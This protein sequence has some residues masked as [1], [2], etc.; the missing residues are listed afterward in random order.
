MN[1]HLNH[2]PMTQEAPGG[3]ITT[4][5]SGAVAGFAA[6]APMTVAME[7]MHRR[8]PWWERYPLPPS[9]IV[10][11]LA[12]ATGLRKHMDRQEHL[13]VT[14]VSHFAYGAAA[15]AG[16]ALVARPLPLPAALK[17]ILF[18]LVVWTVS[19]LG[20]LPSVSI[21]P[22]A[23]EQPQRR[24]ALMIAAHVVWGLVMGTLVDR[25]QERGR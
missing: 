18:G 21:L 17:G 4:I 12:K 10:S 1:T 22:S 19:Y 6:T 16:Y 11:R 7:L 20:W 2:Q 8:L 3:I 9:Q 24:N 15:G 13:A 23:T 14:I 5:R 25:L